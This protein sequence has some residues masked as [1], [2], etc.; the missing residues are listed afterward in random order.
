MEP[1]HDFEHIYGCD[2]SDFDQSR[3]R[4]E[5]LAEQMQ[6]ML[7][8][9]TE[10][11]ELEFCSRPTS[12]ASLL[13]QGK[14]VP[15]EREY[16]GRHRPTIRTPRVTEILAQFKT[17]VGYVL[18]LDQRSERRVVRM[19]GFELMFGEPKVSIMFVAF[20]LKEVYTQDIEGRC[21]QRRKWSSTRLFR[22]TERLN[23]LL[24]YIIQDEWTLDFCLAG[25]GWVRLKVDKEPV[26]ESR[27]NRLMPHSTYPPSSRVWWIGSKGPHY[28]SL[29]PCLHKEHWNDEVLWTVL[30][31]LALSSQLQGLQRALGMY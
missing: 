3:E 12:N 22:K 14:P 16:T 8:A 17:P 2:F 29:K 4:E 30:Y 23:P 11:R 19:P 20:D 6:R 15:T 26:H 5:K 18:I 27:A 21:V 9:R 7:K 31:Y 24:D 28:F 13:F 1:I 25:R 10:N